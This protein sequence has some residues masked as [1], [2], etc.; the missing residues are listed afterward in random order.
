LIRI[1]HE[2]VLVLMITSVVGK[3]LFHVICT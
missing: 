1:M 2:T 3:Y